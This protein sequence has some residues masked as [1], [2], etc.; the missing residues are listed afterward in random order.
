MVRKGPIRAPE[1]LRATVRWDYQPDICKDYKETGF[2]GFGGKLCSNHSVNILLAW[3][4][5]NTLLQTPANSYMTGVTTSMVGRSSESW[6]KVFM[7]KGRMKTGKCLTAMKKIFL[8]SVLFVGKA[9]K[10]LLLQSKMVSV[11]IWVFVDF[12]IVFTDASTTFVKSVHWIIIANRKGVLFVGPKPWA[13]LIQLRVRI[14]T[15]LQV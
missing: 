7:D 2:C 5:L 4:Y 3:I 15:L 9:S 10:L 11:K 12:L 13:F 6:R 1:H 14:V 8:S